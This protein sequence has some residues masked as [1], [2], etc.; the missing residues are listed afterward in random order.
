MWMDWLFHT[1][2]NID[3]FLAAIPL[4]LVMLIYYVSRRHLPLRESRS[5]FYLMVLNLSTLVTDIAACYVIEQHA[6][7]G[8][9]YFWNILYDAS[10]I[11][12]PS[13]LLLYTGDVL[14]VP[15]FAGRWTKAVVFLPVSVLL[16]LLFTTPLTGFFFRSTADVPYRDGPVYPW[17]YDCYIFYVL[18]SILLILVERRKN[19]MERNAAFLTCGFLL[20]LGIYLRSEFRGTLVLAYFFTL[21][22]L[23][24]YLTVRN[25]DFYLDGET[26]LLN[27]PALRLVYADRTRKGPLTGFGFVIR[28][29]E[30]SRALY[31]SVFIDSFL[32]EMGNYLRHALPA[33]DSFYLGSGRFLVLTAAGNLVEPAVEEIRQRFEKPWTNGARTAY[34]DISCIYADRGI[35]FS[36]LEEFLQ[37]AAD[38]FAS[39]KALGVEDIQLNR[40]YMEKLHRRAHVR[41]LLAESLEKDSLEMYLQPLV[42][43][44]SFHLC[45]AEALVRMKD[46]NGKIILPSEFTPMA[47]ENGSI[48]L[49]GLEIFG[50]ACRFIQSGGL[51]RCGMKWVQVNLS[52]LQCLDRHLPDKLDRL[53]QEY[54]VPVSSVRLEITEQAALGDSGYRQLG[55][56]AKRG[57]TLVL[58]DYGSGYSNR[59]RMMAVSAAGI[60]LDNEF[61]GLHFK[62]PDSYLPNLVD[63][64]RKMG[65]E[66][67]AEGVETREMAESLSAMGCSSLQG[68]YFSPPLPV[69]E[70]IK[71]YGAGIGIEAGN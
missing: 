1:R 5:F 67:T 36:S 14:H 43:A 13:F 41:R 49:L 7:T 46:R 62:K 33:C 48:T 44:G 63:G 15:D 54:G 47:E 70:F 61:V 69:E 50:K 53:R 27:E 28:G 66:V 58:D 30:R 2:H 71:K 65:Y 9:I 29:Y 22:I 34:F 59:Q 60:K 18:L 11:L 45:G 17:V 26:N 21:A 35:H 42:E 68:F 24:T 20:L 12:V 38:T 39:A 4:Q 19:S 52:P 56:L 16:L 31:G 3:L 23:V 10:F 57:Y 25:P 64:M 55:E 32:K 37:T 40:A 6:S 8:V 51:G